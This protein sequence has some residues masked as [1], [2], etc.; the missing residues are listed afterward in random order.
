MVF[1]VRFDLAMFMDKAPAR[2]QVNGFT[3]LFGLCV[4]QTRL[5]LASHHN[6]IM[7]VIAPFPLSRLYA[8]LPVQPVRF[9]KSF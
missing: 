2:L 6:G 7:T 3:L 4:N 5:C 1:T 8:V 9:S